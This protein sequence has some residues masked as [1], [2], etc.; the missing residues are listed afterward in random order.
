LEA[1]ETEAQPKILEGVAAQPEEEIPTPLETTDAETQ[2]VVL[3]I[4]EVS[5]KTEEA[6]QFW[7][8]SVIIDR[9]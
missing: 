9:L 5:C 6:F 2:I 3:A 1:Y 8:Q 7:E 4:K